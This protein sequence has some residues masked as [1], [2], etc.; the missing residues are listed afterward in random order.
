MMKCGV[1]LWGWNCSDVRSLTAGDVQ[2]GILC[3]ITMEPLCD[4]N[5]NMIHKGRYILMQEASTTLKPASENTSTVVPSQW[6]AKM[7]HNM[8]PI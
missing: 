3:I 8:V 6:P 5:K 2:L 1:M 4:E 7:Q